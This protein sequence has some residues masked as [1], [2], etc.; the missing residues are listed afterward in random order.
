M[1]TS[2]APGSE[3]AA[4]LA[5]R[6][7]M[8]TSPGA[9]ETLAAGTRGPRGVGG[10]QR[11][12]EKAAGADGGGRRGAQAL[13]REGSLQRRAAGLGRRRRRRCVR[14]LAARDASAVLVV[15]GSGCACGPCASQSNQST[16]RESRLLIFFFC[17][18]VFSSLFFECLSSAYS[19]S[20]TRTPQAPLVYKQTYN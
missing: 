20:Y 14:K 17:A 13:Q 15:S 1:R 18:L 5:P 2:G 10:S 7:V 4:R 11:A 16:T 9:P 8:R 3:V 19:C 6:V 12:A